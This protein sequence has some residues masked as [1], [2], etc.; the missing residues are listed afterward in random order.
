MT[1]IPFWSPHHRHTCIHMLPLLARGCAVV[2]NG[3]VEN[4]VGNALGIPAERVVTLLPVNPL[5]PTVIDFHGQ[6]E[7]VA[8]QP[9]SEDVVET[10]AVGRDDVRQGNRTRP[11]IKTEVV[12]SGVALGLQP[13][14]LGW[15]LA[16]VVDCNAQRVGVFVGR[17]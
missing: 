10:V 5:A 6:A 7:E 12:V 1:S 16:L 9:W 14:V 4:P 2:V 15:T 13:A 17:Q 11:T 8:L 3:T